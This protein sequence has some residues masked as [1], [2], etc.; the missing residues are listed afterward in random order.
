MLLG[1]VTVIVATSS[2]IECRADAAA[3]QLPYAMMMIFGSQLVLRRISASTTWSRS[4]AVIAIEAFLWMKKLYDA[5]APSPPS[6]PTGPDAA[7]A[8]EMFREFCESLES[9]TARRD[10]PSSS[11]S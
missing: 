8:R 11:E 5:F 10:G 6:S 1:L 3:Q 9:G 4:I 2:T 7:E